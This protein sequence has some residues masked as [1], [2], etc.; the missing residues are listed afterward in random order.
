M[1]IKTII[2]GAFLLLIQEVSAQF[3]PPVSNYTTKTYNA[4]NQKLV[5]RSG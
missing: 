3:L 2:Y 5:D 4:D 1:N